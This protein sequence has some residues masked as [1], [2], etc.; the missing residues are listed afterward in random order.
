MIATLLFCT[1]MDQ[2]SK[3]ASY[4]QHKV[5]LVKYVQ[6]VDKTLCSD[7]DTIVETQSLKKMYTQTKSEGGGGEREG[8]NGRIHI[9]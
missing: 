4:I 6:L 1:K 9:K 2:I 7:S 8:R 5:K 3:Q